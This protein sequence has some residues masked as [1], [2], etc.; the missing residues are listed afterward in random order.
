MTQTRRA[1]NRNLW[2]HWSGA[3]LALA[4]LSAI[5]YIWAYNQTPV[6]VAPRPDDTILVPI[7]ILVPIQKAA[8]ASGFST[9]LFFVGCLLAN[10]AAAFVL[11]RLLMVRVPALFDDFGSDQTGDQTYRRIFDNGWVVLFGIALSAAIAA[12][13]WQQEPWPNHA[14]LA[15]ALLALLFTSNI[16]IGMAIASLAVYV[17]LLYHAFAKIKV[18][19]L[20]LSRTD[21]SNFMLITS[22]IT[23]TTGL[24]VFLA[25][26]GILFS[27][28]KLDTSILAFSVLSVILVVATYVIPVAPLTRQA[29]AGKQRELSRIDA[30]IRAEFDKLSAKDAKQDTSTLEALIT[31]RE[32]VTAIKVVPPSSEFSI[33]TAALV[34]ILSFLP[35][36]IDYFVP[37]LT[38]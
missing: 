32:H 30:G 22:M 38:Q 17:H 24:I 28:L 6:V 33:S 5:A 14:R 3:A 12:F 10:A 31:Q 21:I 37:A 36:L 35:A 16:V 9:E 8:V 34:T 26:M 15:Q 19:V 23:F 7:E 29:Y 13:V 18:D 4:G 25:V 11:A 27:S 20:H 2:T 1:Q